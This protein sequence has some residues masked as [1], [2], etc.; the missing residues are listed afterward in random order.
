[1][2]AVEDAAHLYE[3]ERRAGHARGRLLDH[4][5]PIGPALLRSAH[6]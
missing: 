3:V 6:H 4:E 1:M 5:L 2:E